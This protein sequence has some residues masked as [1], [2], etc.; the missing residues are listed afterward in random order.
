MSS[1]CSLHFHF[2]PY[3]T[4][5]MGEFSAA[6]AATV[7][8]AARPAVTPVVESVSKPPLPEGEAIS[9]A[10]ERLFARWAAQDAQKLRQQINIDAA[11]TDEE[12]RKAAAASIAD[13]TET[14][15]EVLLNQLQTED[16]GFA[17]T[18]A[19]DVA[20]Y[21]ATIDGSRAATATVVESAT[22]K[23]ATQAQ[24]E[25]AQKP[26]SEEEA[27][28]ERIRNA[29]TLYDRVR[30]ETRAAP[31]VTTVPTESAQAAPTVTIDQLTQRLNMQ[32]PSEEAPRTTAVP[33]VQPLPLPK[34]NRPQEN[35]MSDFLRTRDEKRAKMGIKP[36]VPVPGST[37]EQAS[38]AASPSTSESAIPN[39]TV[40]EPESIDTS[41]NTDQAVTTEQ[42]KGK[43]GRAGERLKGAVGRIR[44]AATPTT[45]EG[46]ISNTPVD[47]DLKSEPAPDGAK[48]T[49][50]KERKTVREIVQSTEFHTST[51]KLPIPMGINERGKPVIAALEKLPHVLIA[52][53]SRQEVAHMVSS[54]AESLT[55]QKTPEELQLVIINTQKEPSLDRYEGT[56]Y[57]LTPAVHDADQGAAML[58]SIS[59]VMERR[60]LA[61]QEKGYKNIDAFNK[62][63]EN[64]DK[65]PSIVVVV[66]DLKSI[67]MAQPDIA[68]PAITRLAA[69][70]RAVGIH[71]VISTN[72]PSVD[73]VTGLIKANI[74]S[75]IAFAT[76]SDFSSRIVLDAKGAEDLA[77]PG[78][79]LYLP[80][81]QGKPTKILSTLPSETPLPM[82]QPTGEAPPT[83]PTDILQRGKRTAEIMDNTPSERQAEVNTVMEAAL[84]TLDTTSYVSISFL[85]RKLGI[86]Y[87]RAVRLVDELEEQGLL[88][89]DEQNGR[90]YRVHQDAVAQYRERQAALHEETAETNA[91]TTAETLIPTAKSGPVSETEQPS[92]GPTLSEPSPESRGKPAY[93]LLDEE[94]TAELANTDSTSERGRQL[95]RE[96]MIRDA[97]KARQ[98]APTVVE[99]TAAAPIP[100]APANEPKQEGGFFG[101]IKRR[102]SGENKE[103][104]QEAAG[105]P[106]GETVNP[107][108]EPASTANHPA[109]SEEDAAAIAAQ[110]Q[111]EADREAAVKAEEE[112]KTQAKLLA[113]AEAAWGNPL[114]QEQATDIAA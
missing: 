36:P 54:I 104:R 63:A 30:T 42:A 78:E 64:A 72:Q 44:S 56:P 31:S 29:P 95:Q 114:T 83:H 108:P 12:A 14:A 92:I 13:A 20:S 45:T 39:N 106:I 82:R 97:E 11:R 49:P 85:Q 25:A 18:I 10:Q 103:K 58:D 88:E 51:Y 27:L 7:A 59:E 6:P 62:T 79:M 91:T 52:G 2:I 70:A 19:A 28:R 110:K 35:P 71:L 75:R 4:A 101:W 34:N 3:Y 81:D 94:L 76:D 74:P 37:P 68:E 53:Q 66:D 73:S 47:T 9:P 67:M 60:Y 15:R 84:N 86:G 17:T 61:I 32:V 26:L 100:E 46:T 24:T 107:G 33:D 111:A 90:S 57:L 40:T 21:Q 5:T 112:A 109:V 87:P 93:D 99:A 77:E 98:A 102:F 43:L 23:N 55:A 80:Y 16:E 48:E 113:D 41:R 105:T 89:P 22:T 69:K 65:L 8:E 96:Q 1:A 50:Q 38:P